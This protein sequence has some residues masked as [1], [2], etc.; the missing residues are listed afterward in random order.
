MINI[1]G[2]LSRRINLSLRSDEFLPVP[3][4]IRHW[5]T[6][7]GVDLSTDTT[8]HI[9]SFESNDASVGTIKCCSHVDLN[10]LEFELP[11]IRFSLDKESIK[12][13]VE[14]NEIPFSETHKVTLENILCL[15]NEFEKHFLTMTNTKNC[16]YCLLGQR[17]LKNWCTI[18][19]NDTMI[20]IGKNK[21][22]DKLFHP[23]NTSINDFANYLYY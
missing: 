3:L 10:S 17:F 23:T 19:V 11:C 9:K 12:V 1:C 18:Q 14:I 5:F 20:F 16:G 22:C 15:F 13:L 8:W 21:P 6:W 2:I 7:D 4:G